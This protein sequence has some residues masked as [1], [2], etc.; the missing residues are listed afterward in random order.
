MSTKRHRHWRTADE[1]ASGDAGAQNGLR[2]QPFEISLYNEYAVEK[3]AGNHAMARNLLG[4][5]IGPVIEMLRPNAGH[6]MIN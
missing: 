3:M 5:A 6:E 1:G 4:Y 2:F